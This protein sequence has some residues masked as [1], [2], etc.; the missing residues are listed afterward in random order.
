M[1]KLQDYL[2]LAV[3]LLP[4]V[5]L[6]WMN[7][8]ANIKK[9]Q[10]YKQFLMPFAA[11]ILCA[12]SIGLLTKIYDLTLQLFQH[13]DDW[14]DQLGI[15]LAEKMPALDG[16][17]NLLAKLATGI[18]YLVSGVD[19]E[20]WAFYVANALILL[21]YVILKKPILLCM[22]GLFRDGNL[23]QKLA[24]LF[25][26]YD[27]ESGVWSLQPKFGQAR[28]FLKTLYI[29]AVVLG[30]VGVLISSRLYK[31]GLLH[32]IY[33]PVF[34]VIILGELYFALDGLTRKELRQHQP[35]GEDDEAERVTNYA[36]MRDVLRKLFP[37]KLNAENTTVSAV[38]PGATTTEELLAELESSEYVAVEAYG[39]YMRSKSQAGME[40]DFNY[41][42]SGKLLSQILANFFSLDNTLF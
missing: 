29:S 3:M 4:F 33:Y 18:R 42:L 1:T 35:G 15:R 40:L 17:A 9:P 36:T 41:F 14:V 25:Y 19:Q 22:K 26:E 16:L 34:S 2:P 28:V 37:D 30:A 38:H 39:R 21:A 13:A 11:L 8:K 31:L 32:A 7:Y 12:L 24:G 5:V 20:F 10:R 27:E 6:C 23:F